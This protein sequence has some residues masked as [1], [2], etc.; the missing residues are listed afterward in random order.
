[1]KKDICRTHQGRDTK[2]DN[3][4]AGRN[5]LT[6]RERGKIREKQRKNDRTA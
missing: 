4:P 3:N 1:M 6:S 2:E 5:S